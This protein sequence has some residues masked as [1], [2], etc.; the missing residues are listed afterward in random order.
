MSFKIPPYLSKEFKTL[1]TPQ[2]REK[3]INSYR[4]WYDSH[5]TTE[6]LEHLSC[7]IQG[8]L[9]DQDSE[10]NFSTLF[11]SKYYEAGKKGERNVLRK[12]LKQ[13]NPEA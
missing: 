5:F 11:Q 8:S 7:L 4:S 1:K 9:L 12:I 2:E 3:F 10:F 6:L 13:V